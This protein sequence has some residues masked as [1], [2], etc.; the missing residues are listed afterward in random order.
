MIMTTGGRTATYQLFCDLDKAIVVCKVASLEDRQ[1]P[2]P[3]AEAIAVLKQECYRKWQGLHRRTVQDWMK[4]YHKYKELGMD[5]VALYLAKAPTKARG[6]KPLIPPELFEEL[7]GLVRTYLHTND[8]GLT[9]PILQGFI[10]GVLEKDPRFQP[11]R[12]GRLGLGGYLKLPKNCLCTRSN[13]LEATAI[14]DTT[15]N[16]QLE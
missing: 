9:G 1:H 12:L 6:P 5:D 7:G 16:R 15:S 4:N 14:L 2:H 10:K 8:A 11:F 3:I 13:Y